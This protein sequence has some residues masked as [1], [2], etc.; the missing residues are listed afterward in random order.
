LQPGNGLR[1][2]S[3][4]SGAPF[5]AGGS[6]PERAESRYLLENAWFSRQAGGMAI[7][8]VMNRLESI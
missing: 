6:R 1:Q 2:F 7:V 4:L 5:R 3:A 8:S